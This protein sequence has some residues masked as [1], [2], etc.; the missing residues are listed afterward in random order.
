[1]HQLVR[2]DNG[3]DRASIAAMHAANTQG[4]VDNCDS[5]FKCRVLHQ[6]QWFGAEQCRKSPHSLLT[7]GWAQVDPCF[8]VND[9]LRIGAAT[10]ETTLR[11]LSLRQ[12]FIDLLDECFGIGGQAPPCVTQGESGGEG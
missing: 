3:I 9:R 10:R 8:G 2:A 11:A 4:F 6:W 12:Y 5:P 1:V 7:P